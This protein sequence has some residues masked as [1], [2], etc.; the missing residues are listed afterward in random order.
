MYPRLL[1][2]CGPVWIQAYGTMIAVG[3][4]L[5]L[6]LTY[7]HPQR[8]KLIGNETYLNTVFSRPYKWYHRRTSSVCINSPK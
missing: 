1:H 2:I 5:F 4:L 3:F 8:Q 6:Y 7:R